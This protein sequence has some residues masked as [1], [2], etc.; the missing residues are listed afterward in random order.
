MSNPMSNLEKA[1]TD[2]ICAELPRLLTAEEV[3]HLSSSLHSLQLKAD[4]HRTENLLNLLSW[5][6]TI[7]D[8]I[9]GRSVTPFRCIKEVRDL[10]TCIEIL[11]REH[12]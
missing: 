4:K 7:C 6:I 8:F 3:E 9:T 12:L 5:R 11:E 1:Y 2:M 10:K